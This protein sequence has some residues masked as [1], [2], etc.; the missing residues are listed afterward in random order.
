MSEIK[1]TIIWYDTP[2]KH[3]DLKIRW[4][5]D[6]LGQTEFFRLLS[7]VYLSQDERILA[8]IGEYQEKKMIQNKTKRKKTKK[9]YKGAEK[10]KS[11]FSLKEDEVESIFDLLA[12]EHPDL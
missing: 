1:K 2:K 8:I 10:V 11:N 3:A 7:D 5:Y 12:E 6:D 4:K 9:I